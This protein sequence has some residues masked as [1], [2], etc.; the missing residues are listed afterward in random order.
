MS[1][2]ISI[3]SGCTSKVGSSLGTPKR[4]GP[5]P[6]KF[7]LSAKQAVDESIKK[8]QRWGPQGTMEED[9]DSPSVSYHSDSSVD[10]KTF[11][12][13]Y[14]ILDKVLG[15]V[16]SNFDLKMILGRFFNC[17]RSYAET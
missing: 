15:E 1:A 14:Q 16:S 10:T 3:K 7:S 9:M 12:Q 13:K 2:N 4:S 11:E 17:Q 8:L 5:S 6:S